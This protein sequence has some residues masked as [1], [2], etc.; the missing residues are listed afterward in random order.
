MT[1]TGP[2][3]PDPVLRA[4]IDRVVVPALLDRLLDRFLAEMR[5]LREDDGQP[6]PEPPD[7]Q[8]R[9]GGCV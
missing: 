7:R 5:E 2:A 9:R 4:F 8:E 6:G 1:P 3:A